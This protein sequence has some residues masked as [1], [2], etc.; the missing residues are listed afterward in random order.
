MIDPFLLKNLEDRMQKP[1]DV[2]KKELTTIRTGRATPALLDRIQ[3]DAYGQM[4]PINQVANVSVPDARTLLIQPW[5]KTLLGAV[6]KAILKSDIGIHPVNDGNAIRL[7]IPALTE[8]RR[9]DLV[10][11]VKKKAE[12]GKVSLR[13]IRR[14]FNDEL[15][16]LEKAGTASEDEVRTT[17]DKG[18]KLTDRYIKDFDDI[19]RHKEKEIMEI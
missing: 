8:E 17:Q 12:E 4:M 13:N 9:K 3:V 14:D 7:A 10:K 1:V 5:D 15:K 16:K 11:V 6:E 18:Q 19:S 2:F